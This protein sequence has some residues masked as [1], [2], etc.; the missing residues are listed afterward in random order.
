MASITKRPYKYDYQTGDWSG[1]KYLLDSDLSTDACPVTTN[2]STVFLFYDFSQL[3]TNAVIS[4]VTTTIKYK[5]SKSTTNATVMSYRI[6]KD[7]TSSSS[8]TSLQSS[9]TSIYNSTAEQTKTKSIS[10]PQEVIDALNEDIDIL[11]NS[12][13]C[14]RLYCKTG[15]HG[16]PAYFYDVKVE[17]TYTS[18]STITTV[19]QPSGCGTVS[20]G[21]TYTDGSSVTLTATPSNGY[22]FSKW[23]KDGVDDG[24]TSATRTITVS[25]NATYTAVF[26][27]KNYSISTSVSP[28]G[29]G[30]VTGGGTYSH[31]SSVILTATAAN[32]YRFVKWQTNGSDDGNT[33]ATRTV[34]A[35]GNVTYTAVFELTNITV[36]FDA[37]GGS[38]ST[39]SKSVTPG[40][41]YGTLPTPTRAGYTFAGWY[42]SPPVYNGGFLRNNENIALGRTYMYTDKINVKIYA[43]MDD[44]SGIVNKNLISCTEG[45]GWGIGYLA[46]TVGHGTEVYISGVGYKGIDFGIT[47]LSSGWH[48]FDMVF[49]GSIFYGYVDG[50]LK[51]SVSTGG[52][53]IAYHSSNGIFIG[54]EAGSNATSGTGGYFNGSVGSVFIANTN[55][56]LVEITS[57]T[58]VT[59]SSAHTLY[60]AWEINH[61][62]TTATCSN[63]TVNGTTSY[64]SVNPHGEQITL[65]ASP[66]TGYHFTAWN[67]GNTSASRTVTVQSSASYTANFALNSYNITK[68][69]SHATLSN[70]ST[71]VQHGSSYSSTVTADTDYALD[72]VTVTMGGTDITS[73]AYSNGSISIASVTG[74]ISITVTTTIARL[75]EV[76]SVT[77]SPNPVN[78]GQGLVL[79]VVFT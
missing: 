58:T 38:V 23:Q 63:G 37:S 53:A 61:Y 62:T 66:A 35:T 30:T 22:Q 1:L 56:R 73:T 43:Y 57:G 33:S 77:I 65:T 21:G 68:T 2:A 13:F 18:T 15:Q 8:Y 4:D 50:V 11:C 70:S 59:N 54:A 78:A 7:A 76:S 16:A 3:S 5:A 14:V 67:D 64:S 28:S 34:T 9:P 24:N 27:L 72:T 32:G 47:S 12:R 75:P 40:S 42:T 10:S 19:V 46:N 69:L 52:T 45:G 26:V 31:G 51:G 36:S 49:D 74:S 71:T 79:T 20:G 55:A 6:C 41:T 25:S 44:W 48:C 29:A 39:S 60:A 17:I